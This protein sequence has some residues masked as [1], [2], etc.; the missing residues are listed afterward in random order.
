M[1]PYTTFAQIY[2]IF[3]ED[4]PYDAWCGRI[5]KIL[6]EFGIRDGLVLDLA[7]G[8]GQMTRRLRDAGFDMIGV[9]LSAEMLQAAREADDPCEED[10]V[11]SD[12]PWCSDHGIL[13]LQQDMREFELYGTVRA[14]VCLCDSMNYLLEEDDLLK[15]FRLANNYLDPG[16]IFIFDM[17]TLHKYRDELGEC[18][19]CENREHESF[20]WENYFDEESGINEYD[21]TFFV[22]EENGLFRRTQETHYQ[23]A[24]SPD[25]VARLLEEAGM[26][27]LAVY[28]EESDIPP[29][30]TDGRIYF[31]AQEQ[32][33]RFGAEA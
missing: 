32:G 33:K 5:R 14:I 15:V 1:N 20:L 7:C 24:Y 13:Y 22:E 21:V 26:K 17:N 19:I 2:D 9:D 6:A 28:G 16:G 3:M 10:I 8:T 25:L 31:I 4:V 27:L 11:L 23:R 12:D 18:C 30:D 29:A